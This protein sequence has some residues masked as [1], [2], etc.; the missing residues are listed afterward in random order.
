VPQ[1]DDVHDLVIRGGTVVDG[2][3]AR[4]FVG[5]VAIDGGCITAVAREGT[6]V[7]D[8]REVVD[9]RGRIVTPGFVDP[10]THYDGQVTWDP[11]LAPSSWHGVTTVVMGNCGVG[12][13]PAKPHERRWLI[14]L[15]EGVE[16]IPGTAL[17][18]GIRWSWETF[19]EYLDALER[20]PRAIDVAAQIP[21]G[22]VRLYAMGKRGADQ[23]PATAEDLAAM[24]QIVRDGIRAGALAF[25]T[26]RLPLHTSIHGEPVP[27]T[28][29]DR[30]ELQALAQAVIDG[31][32]AL[33]QAVPAGSMGEDKDGPVRD[34]ELY[35]EI[36]LATGAA[37]TF[38][39]VQIHAN[40][41][42]WREV[43]ARSARANAAGARLVPQVLAR[44]AG[45]LASFEAFN[46]FAN[47]PAYQ[48]VAQL[49]MAER[50][51]RLREPERRMRLLSEGRFDNAGMG[52]MRHSLHS[53]FAMDDGV[54]FEPHPDQSIAARAA[55]AGVDPIEM[56][57]D[58]LCDLADAPVGGKTRMLHVYFSGYAHGDLA[59]IGEML[60]SDLTVAGLADGGAHC[61]MICDA[62]M[63]TFVLAHWVRDR[64]RGPKLALEDAIRRL[65][66]A[67]A[68]LYG[69]GDR[70]V[71]AVGKRADLNVIDL[72]RIELE[73]PEITPDLPAGARRVL[74][75]GRGYAA[76]ICAGEV[77]FRD[78]EPTGARPGRLVRGRR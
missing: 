33:V 56:L 26:N 52:I 42:Q 44:P 28:F 55:R 58:T 72:D 20:M 46:P 15:M 54:V 30:A 31:G 4:P 25:S 50:V 22:A 13:A 37:F 73:L 45:L 76:T 16:D 60:A 8:A 35:R 62:S 14:E 39:T 65:S 24:A 53:A 70:G 23:Q 1:G 41:E 67:P 18:E 9:A 27:G 38:S 19:P 29:A 17:H 51:R 5:D 71:V 7:S 75:R 68:E 32:G 11:I 34:V 57:F 2:T 61:S 40:P 43:L 6:L 77:T 64:T 48:E 66:S 74:Q 47:R 63:P 78:G 10:H 36:S 49:P 21:H 69:L 12:F 3:G 59:A